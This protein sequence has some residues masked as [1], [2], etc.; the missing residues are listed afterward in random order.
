M[1]SSQTVQVGR[2]FMYRDILYTNADPNWK[3]HVYICGRE[4][5]LHSIYRFF[6]LQFLDTGL[7]ASSFV[8]LNLGYWNAE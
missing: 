5:S 3:N 4:L 1:T 7:F 8:M 6:L 2:V